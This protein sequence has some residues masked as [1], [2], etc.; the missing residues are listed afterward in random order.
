MDQEVFNKRLENLSPRRREVLNQLLTG[1]SYEEIANKLDIVESTLRKHVSAIYDE[2]VGDLFPEKSRIRFSDLEKLIHQ[3]QPSLLNNST[4]LPSPRDTYIERHPIDQVCQEEI[5]Q[6]GA[7]LVIKAP[8]K[9]GK[10]MLL[11][12]VIKNIIQQEYRSVVLS[13]RLAAKNSFYTEDKQEKDK[14]NIDDL[15]YWL[16]TSVTQTLLLSGESIG[17]KDNHNISNQEQF[18]E[19]WETSLGDSPVKCTTYF[20]KYLLSRNK[21]LVL[22]LDDLDSLDFDSQFNNTVASD[23]FA[24]L[25]TWH[26]KAAIRPIWDNLRLIL[27]QSQD[28][29]LNTLNR[30][31]LANIGT[32]IKLE[33][34]TEEQVKQLGSIYKLK[35]QNEQ[36]KALMELVGGHPYLIHEA[37]QTVARW[38][39]NLDKILQD[40]TTETGIYGSYLVDLLRKLQLQIDKENKNMSRDLSLETNQE[41]KTKLKNI[42]NMEV[43]KSSHSSL[44]ESL[45]QLINHKEGKEFESRIKEILDEL[46]LIKREGNL[47]FLR[48]ELYRQYLKQ[49]VT[50]LE[51]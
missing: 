50:Y 28:Y 22:G 18:K 23:F 45:K 5:R 27:V 20:E 44:L 1:K 25:R 37:V 34:F 35:L 39:T 31:P 38:G 7:L 14:K 8:P 46:G 26:E 6:P 29:T 32:H 17:N 43:L 15:L 40:A 3:Y 51:N 42:Q 33:E 49:Q 30:S 16:C 24:L 21:P 9:M 13:V 47:V 19:F 48:C 12:Q 11:S 36:I 4:P 10:T 2:L 41:N